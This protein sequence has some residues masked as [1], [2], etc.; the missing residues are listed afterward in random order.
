MK[1]KPNCFYCNGEAIS[2][3]SDCHLVSFCV[4]KQHQLIHKDG[5]G[6]KCL[7]FKVGSKQARLSVHQ[8]I[9]NKLNMYSEVRKFGILICGVMFIV[10]SSFLTYSSTTH[11][12]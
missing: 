3:C 6:K 9:D 10:C 8:F 11:D 1:P 7:P 2:E 4:D 5:E 12:L